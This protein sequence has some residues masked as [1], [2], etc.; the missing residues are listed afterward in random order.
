VRSQAPLF[1]LCR[2]GPRVCALPADQVVETLRPLPI[3]D[4]PG[5]PRFV[6]GG[7]VIRGVATPVV[8]VAALLGDEGPAMTAAAAATGVGTAGVGRFVTVRVGERRV[9]LAVD[10]VTDVRTLP[11]DGLASLP[12]LLAGA[13]ADVVA[14][15][16]ALD[17]DVLVVLRSARLVPEATFAALEGSGGKGR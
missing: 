2:V 9:A 12:P 3:A 6:L 10:A 15:L 4:L 13:H 16:G 5:A 11:E 1:V 17:T 14:A 8:S 7:S